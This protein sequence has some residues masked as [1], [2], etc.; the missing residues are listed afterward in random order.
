MEYPKLEY[1]NF[2][3]SSFAK[4]KQKAEVA[5]KNKDSFLFCIFMLLKSITVIHLVH[6]ATT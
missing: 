3:Y 2:L 1:P 6:A 4:K 5:P